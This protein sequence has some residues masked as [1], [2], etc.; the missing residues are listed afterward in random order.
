MAVQVVDIL[1]AA[2]HELRDAQESYK[3]GTL[4]RRWLDL[5]A[6]VMPAARTCSCNARC[7]WVLTARFCWH[8]Y[9]CSQQSA[10]DSSQVQAS[11]G[12]GSSISSKLQQQQLAGELSSSSVN[13]TADSAEARKG[14]K[15]SGR[16][17]WAQPNPTPANWKQDWGHFE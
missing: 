15:S 8:L 11:N 3:Q 10:T 6:C 2:S 4:L 13:Y 9:D 16:D 17:P 12:S 5:H 7:C 14:N 1:H